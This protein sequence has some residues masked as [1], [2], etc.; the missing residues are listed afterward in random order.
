[1][2]P[3]SLDCAPPYPSRAS[4]RTPP[5]RGGKRGRFSLRSSPSFAICSCWLSLNHSDRQGQFGSVSGKEGQARRRKLSRADG[6]PRFSLSRKFSASAVQIVC[7]RARLCVCVCV[8]NVSLLSSSRQCESGF[9]AIAP[10]WI[11]FRVNRFFFG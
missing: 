1:M 10:R 4:L 6:T 9:G 7:P 11:L 8:C 3:T 5:Y 2:A